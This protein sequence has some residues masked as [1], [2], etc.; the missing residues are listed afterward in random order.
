[1]PTKGAFSIDAIL[2]SPRTPRK[3]SS[4][5]SLS[6]ALSPGRE[7]PASPADTVSSEDSSPHSPD[8][9]RIPGGIAMGHSGVHR[10]HPLQMLYSQVPYMAPSHPLMARLQQ[11]TSVPAGIPPMGRLGSGMTPPPAMM[12]PQDAQYWQMVQ[13]RATGLMPRMSEPMM[14]GRWLIVITC[15]YQIY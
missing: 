13:A 8:A 7:S 2:G 12:T 14:H 1:M 15:I 10:P 9:G 6:P 4:S 5:D 11:M 3:D